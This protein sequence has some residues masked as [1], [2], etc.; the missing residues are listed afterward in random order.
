MDAQGHVW[1]AR[2][3]G[4]CVVKHDQKTG[5]VVE[6]FELPTTNITCIAFGGE[7]R[8][9]AYITSA[10]GTPPGSAGSKDGGSGDG[11]NQG[12]AG[13]LFATVIPGVRGVAEH[14][15]AVGL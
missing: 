6:R 1:S 7:D 4:G 11:G 3:G 15:S 12:P 2:W 13:G 14:R 8:D 5:N 10:G 9:T